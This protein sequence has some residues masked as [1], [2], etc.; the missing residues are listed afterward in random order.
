MIAT[1]YKEM[2]GHDLTVGD[3]VKDYQV[4]ERHGIETALGGQLNLRPPYQREFIYE[5]KSQ[6][7]VVESVLK[8]YPLN[9]FYFVKLDDGSL[10][11]LDGKQR[12]ISLCR[13]VNGK[14]SIPILD[15]GRVRN[16]NFDELDARQKSEFLHYPLI[17]FVCTG[18]PEES[19]DWFRVINLSGLKLTDQEAR[20][21]LYVSPYVVDA[22]SY[23]SGNSSPAY[24][25]EGHK[26]NDHAYS[27]YLNVMNN[28]A[29]ENANAII[30]QKLLETVLSWS[31]DLYAKEHPSSK[32]KISI[33]DYMRFMKEQKNARSLWRYYED[34]MEW[35]KETFPTYNLIMSKVDWG[36]LYNEFRDSDLSGVDEKANIILESM[37]EISNPKEVYRAVLSGDMKWLNGRSFNDIDKR[38]AYN[39]QEHKCAYCHH[40]FDY[41]QMSGDHIIP[42]SKGGKTDRDNL[43]M[44]CM[45]CNLKKSAYDVA[46]SPYDNKPYVKFDLKKWDKKEAPKEKADTKIEEV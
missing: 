38:W 32:G 37:D 43:Q 33:D 5:L 35:V 46:Y 28:N 9:V 23:F 44:L 19:V 36:N 39:K 2:Y 24:Y 7:A 15:G 11:I 30:R 20:N 45:A 1:I 21:A 8:K 31:S 13:Y 6:Q 26:L 12:I 4:D 34:V 14:F 3:L 27:D 42:W 40:E 10:E 16:F 22:K 17:A 41:N 29:P 25:S 18:S